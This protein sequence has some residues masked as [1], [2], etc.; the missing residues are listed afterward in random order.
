M[1]KREGRGRAI[2]EDGNSIHRIDDRTYTVRSQSCPGRAY[3]V[4]QTE[5]GLTCTCPDHTYSNVCC[6]HIHAVA[7]SRR[8]REAVCSETVIRAPDLGRCKHCGS[9][10]VVKH[11]MKKLKRGPVQR[12]KCADCLRHFTHNLGFEGKHATPEQITMAVDLVFSGLSSRKT[13]AAI[14]GMNVRASHQTVMN[15]ADEYGR[16]MDKYLDK[17]RPQ[18]GEKW[19]TDELYVKIRGSRKYL[20]AVLDTETRFWIAKMVAEHKG[21]DDVAPMFA[22]A[23]EVAGKIPETLISDK[24]DN[25]HHAWKRQYRA[26]NFLHKQT[27]HINEVT[28]DGRYHNNQMESFNGN[29][30]RH[31]EK[32]VRGLKKDDS[33]IITGLR[34]YHNFV[35]PTSDCPITSPRP[36]LRASASRAGTGGSP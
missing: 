10:N 30:L 2:A 1:D 33:A 6:K 17:I 3:D 25:F 20:F 36:R 23:R 16:L 12:F 29:T 7:I 21:N 34:L 8:M 26:K 13:A 28:F 15:W 4:V 11:G 9:G 22:K 19:R 24:A 5:R 31:R 32:V 27:E 18:V 14:R 35:R